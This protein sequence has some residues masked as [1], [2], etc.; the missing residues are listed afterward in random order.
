MPITKR[1]LDT[2]HLRRTLP[3]GFGWLD[4]RLLTG[5]YL[6]RLN[7]EALGLYCLLVCAADQQG[8]SYYSDQRLS[9]LLSIDVPSLKIARRRLLDCGLIAYQRPLCQVLA[10]DCRSYAGPSSP[11]APPLALPNR[12]RAREP[13]R[14]QFP[15]GLNLRA[16][17]EASLREG[18]V[19]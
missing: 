10:L 17:V 13:E 18:G 2:I 6:L 1:P 12:E 11:S 7:A 9:R 8:L 19:L 5:S 3:R 14:A 15:T 4:H 16:M